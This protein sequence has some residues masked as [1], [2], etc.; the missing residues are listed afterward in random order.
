M[1]IAVIKVVGRR[2]RA[3]E[4]RRVFKVAFHA[5]VRPAKRILPVV[6]QVLIEFFVLIIGHIFGRERP[7]RLGVIHLNPFRRLGFAFF[8]SGLCFKEVDGDRNMVRVLRDRFAKRPRCEECLF[9]LLHVK[10]DVGAAFSTGC[11]FAREGARTVGFPLHRFVFGRAGSTRYDRYFVGHDKGRVKAHAELSDL[12]RIL[13]LI[14]GKVLEKVF[15]AG[16]RNRAEVLVS[17]FERHA[18]AVVGNGERAGLFVSTDSDGKSRIALKE[19]RVRNGFKPQLID[20]VRRVRDK[21][22]QKHLFVGV[23]RVGEELKELAHLGLKSMNFCSHFLL[24]SPKNAFG[25][26]SQV[27]TSSR[28]ALKSPINSGYMGTAA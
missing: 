20:G 28:R 18:D 17:L 26:T 13:G 2:R 8:F 27:F 12:L 23:E 5:V 4:E 15:R 9:V 19:F 25:R 14:S 16:L 24:V 1:H 11:E 6:R 10:N 21:L 7:K 22:A 3:E